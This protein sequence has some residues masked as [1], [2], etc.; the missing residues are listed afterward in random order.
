MESVSAFVE[1]GGMDLEAELTRV[2]TR[3]DLVDFVRLMSVVAASPES[4]DWENRSLPRFLE[5]LS[6]WLG[7]MSGYYRNQ[8]LEVPD[9]P[10]WRLVADMLVAATIYE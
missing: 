1:L 6:A 9:L 8:G 7:S 10:T 5:A 4:D 3:E 2:S